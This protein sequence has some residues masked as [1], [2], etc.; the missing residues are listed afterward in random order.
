M[1]RQESEQ[2]VLCLPPP[3]NR[4]SLHPEAGSVAGKGIVKP[5]GT[6]PESEAL[7][8]GVYELFVAFSG[9]RAGATPLALASWCLECP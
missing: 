1:R 4:R 6:I 2:S 5:G 3:G 9:Q 8:G 7:R